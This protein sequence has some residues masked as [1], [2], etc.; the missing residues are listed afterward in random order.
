MRKTDEKTQLGL[1]VLLSWYGGAVGARW[2]L[3]KARCAHYNF[4]SQSRCSRKCTN[5]KLTHSIVH[6][7][8]AHPYSWKS[9]LQSIHSPTLNSFAWEKQFCIWANWICFSIERR[10][11]DTVAQFIY[12]F[13]M[14]NL[15]NWLDEEEWQSI[16]FMFLKYYNFHKLMHVFFIM[17]EIQMVELHWMGKSIIHKSCERIDKCLIRRF[18]KRLGGYQCSAST[19]VLQLLDVD[20]R[21][22]HLFYKMSRHVVSKFY[23]KSIEEHFACL[24]K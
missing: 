21:S 18:F 12:K 11:K 13:F 14:F 15:F 6:H 3:Y 1:I 19:F 23:G 24:A 8:E 2:F 20:W 17:N 9:T 22:I 10:K 4:P 16:N 7:P 5:V